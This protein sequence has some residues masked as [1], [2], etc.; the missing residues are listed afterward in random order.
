MIAALTILGSG[1][2]Y[3]YTE[4]RKKEKAETEKSVIEQK[5]DKVINKVDYLIVR[6]SIKTIMLKDFG[7]ELKNNTKSVNAVVYSFG[8]HLKTDKKIEELFDF[9]KLLQE[10]VKKNAMSGYFLIQ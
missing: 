2:T 3:I 10:D 1:V 4:G 5:V 8:S 9:M 7:G 6:D